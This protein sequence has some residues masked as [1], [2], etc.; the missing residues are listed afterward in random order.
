MKYLNS[1]TEP[2]RLVRHSSEGTRV[3][4]RLG[5]KVEFPDHLYP[6]GRQAATTRHSC[7]QSPAPNATFHP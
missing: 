2:Q 7:A 4:D 1:L 3:N 5:R 6:M